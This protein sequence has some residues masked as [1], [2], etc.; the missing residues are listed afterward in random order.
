MIWTYGKVIERTYFKKEPKEKEK[1]I[2]GIEAPYLI[3]AITT[4]KC[5]FQKG[6]KKE[7][8]KKRE[9]REISKLTMNMFRKNKLSTEINQNFR[10][11]FWLLKICG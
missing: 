3:E 1:I 9:T 8:I 10:C 7:R 11:D 4:D 5:R 2:G 6:N